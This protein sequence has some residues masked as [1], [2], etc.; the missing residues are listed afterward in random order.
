MQSYKEL[1]L[2]IAQDADSKLSSKAIHLFVN[3]R[4]IRLPSRQRYLIA[5]QHTQQ[6]WQMHCKKSKSNF[7][8]FLCLTFIRRLRV[9]W[10]SH[11]KAMIAIQYTVHWC[12]SGFIYHLHYLSVKTGKGKHCCERGY[13]FS[14]LSKVHVFKIHVVRV[15]HWSSWNTF[16]TMM[17][18]LKY[19][20]FYQSPSLSSSIS[21]FIWHFAVIIII[22]IN[23][24]SS[25]GL[26]MSRLELSPVLPHQFSTNKTTYE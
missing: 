19:I 11:Y 1:L 12:L 13:V 20:S 23:V 21:S 14:I 26:Y 8:S 17:Q 25:F 18:Y 7:I 10:A 4:H 15:F 5:S 2:S 6:Q 3:L 24:M 9:T 16:K 22:V